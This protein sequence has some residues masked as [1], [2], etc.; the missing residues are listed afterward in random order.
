MELTYTQNGDYLIPNLTAEDPMEML[1]KYGPLSGAAQADS[2]PDHAAERRTDG[3]SSGDRQDGERAVE[4]PDAGAGEAS[5]RNGTAES[6]GPAGV[7]GPDEQLEST[8]EGADSD[9][10][11]VQL[12]LAAILNGKGMVAWKIRIRKWQY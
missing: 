1:G 12:S 8:G 7:G 2:I 6:D 4:Q 5:G 9:G 11:G 3:T 10:T